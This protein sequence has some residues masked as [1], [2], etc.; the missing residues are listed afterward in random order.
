MPSSVPQRCYLTVHVISSVG[1]ALVGVV[2][3]AMLEESSC[4]CEGV[5]AAEA[6][7]GLRLES[8]CGLDGR[9][10]FMSF[11]GTSLSMLSTQRRH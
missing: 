2:G 4:V 9:C 6:E 3:L 10:H 8:G 11:V 5:E 7:L 1:V